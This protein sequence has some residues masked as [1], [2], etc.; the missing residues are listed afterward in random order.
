MREFVEVIKEKVIDELKAGTGE[1]I[2]IRCYFLPEDWKF[3]DQDQIA[4]I[5]VEGENGAVDSEGFLQVYR[6]DPND[7]HL[8]IAVTEPGNYNIGVKVNSGAVVAYRFFTLTV[9]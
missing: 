5:W 4:D 8:T 7:T 9:E 3:L 1:K 2:D 6:E